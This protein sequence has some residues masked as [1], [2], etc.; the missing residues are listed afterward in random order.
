MAYQYPFSGTDE[1]TTLRVWRRGKEIEG[2]DASVW[3]HDICG[4]VMKYLEHG[5]TVSD[6]GWEI[7]HIHPTAKGGANTWD[8]LQ[9]LNWKNNRAKGDT[10]PWRCGS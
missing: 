9:P 4:H 3:R 5:N 7:D 2:Y 6:H 10:Y 1:D 8:N